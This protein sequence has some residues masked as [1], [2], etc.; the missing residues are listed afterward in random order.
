MHLLF[1]QRLEFVLFSFSFNSILI[2]FFSVNDNYA[3]EYVHF[4]TF[5]YVRVTARVAANH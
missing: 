4:H 3:K 2:I 5:C 1:M